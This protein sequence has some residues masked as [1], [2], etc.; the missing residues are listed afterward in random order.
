MGYIK[1]FH[2]SCNSKI[3]HNFTIKSPN[4]IEVLGLSIYTS[5][6]SNDFLKIREARL[7]N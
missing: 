4:P 7:P 5:E 1:N 2:K 3:N 6:V